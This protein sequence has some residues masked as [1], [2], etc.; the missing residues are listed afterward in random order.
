MRHSSKMVLAVVLTVI[1]FSAVQVARAGGPEI[2]KLLIAEGAIKEIDR[3]V[4][5]I[6]IDTNSGVIEI[7]G[8]PFGY[9]ERE[10]AVEFGED[11]AMAVGDCVEVEYALVFCRCTDGSKNIAVELKSYC[12]ATIEDGCVDMDMEYCLSDSVVLRDEDFYPMD[13]SRNDDDSDHNHYHKHPDSD[14]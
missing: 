13:K 2:D 3:E 1:M 8:F 7:T 11:F 9:L 4:S 10:M 5:T 12:Q 14:G 6:K